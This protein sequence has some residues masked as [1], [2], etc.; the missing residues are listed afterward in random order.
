MNT[1]SIMITTGKTINSYNEMNEPNTVLRSCWQCPHSNPDLLNWHCASSL[2]VMNG[3][4]CNSQM[5]RV[6]A[7]IIAFNGM[8]YCLITWCNDII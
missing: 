7:D 2:G 5:D 1:K 3:E 6:S 4:A 8:E